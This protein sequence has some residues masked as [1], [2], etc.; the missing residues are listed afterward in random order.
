MN[1]GVVDELEVGLMKLY[2]VRCIMDGQQKK[3]LEF[4]MNKGEEGGGGR[5][6]VGRGSKSWGGGIGEKMF[7]LHFVSYL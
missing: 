7:I 1:V 5:V 4:L 2:L 3:V 6:G